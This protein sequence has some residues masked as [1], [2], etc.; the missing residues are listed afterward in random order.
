MG[1]D[2]CIEKGLIRRGQ[3]AALASL[4]EIAYE[5]L[6]RTWAL[7]FDSALRFA[8]SSLFDVIL[9]NLVGFQVFLCSYYQICFL[10]QNLQKK[11]GKAIKGIK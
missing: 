7:C 8:K 5:Q 11:K 4:L 6:C 9:Y 10:C 2:V 3:K 1:C